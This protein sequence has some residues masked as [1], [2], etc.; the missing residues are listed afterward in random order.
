MHK[1]MAVVG[2]SVRLRDEALARLL[3][4]WRGAVKRAHEPAD[5][6][7]VLLD[8]DADSL[9][10]TPTLWLLRASEA[11]LQRHAAA[12]APL[13]GQTAQQG[14]IVL[15]LL[16]LDRRQGLGQRLAEQGA[17]IDAAPP[18]AG[19]RPWETGAAARLWVAERLSAHAPGVQQPLRCAELIHAHAGDDADALLTAI[20]QACIYAGDEA[21]TPEAVA[22]VLS[23]DAARPAYEFAAA[24]LAGEAGRAFALWHAARFEPQQAL[25]ILQHEVRRWL[26][27]LESG[28]DGQAAQLAGLKG[29]PSLRAARQQAQALGRPALLRLL[30]GI[31]Q[32]QRELRG[33]TRDP[34]A[35]VELLVLHARTLVQAARRSPPSPAR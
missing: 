22:A 27:C 4:G 35:A 12:L 33:E 34:Q 21:L 19:L 15:S 7:A 8:I 2:P 13:A 20:E 3:A 10:G 24:V 23:G 17:L 28:D 1:L 9:F 14:A 16:T 6:A 29:R 25:A 26:A 32:T 18:W 5:L 11:W 30:A 31:L